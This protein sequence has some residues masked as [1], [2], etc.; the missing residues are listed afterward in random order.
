M[1]MYDMFGAFGAHLE[2][3]IYNPFACRDVACK[4]FSMSLSIRFSEDIPFYN[5][6]LIAK[7][8]LH[9]ST[10]KW[11]D[12]IQVQYNLHSGDGFQSP[13]SIYVRSNTTVLCIYVEIW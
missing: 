6:I 13:V 8:R 9:D 7:I 4:D 3:C 11:E 5:L 1:S 12:G 10:K 2:P